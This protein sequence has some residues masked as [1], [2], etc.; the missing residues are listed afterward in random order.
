MCVILEIYMEYLEYQIE[1]NFELVPE[2]ACSFSAMWSSVSNN[3]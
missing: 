1:F 2:E 3:S